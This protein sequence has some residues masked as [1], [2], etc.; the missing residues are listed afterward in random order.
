MSL[1]VAVLNDSDQVVRS[2]GF[3]VDEHW[4]LVQIAENQSLPLLGRLRDFYSDSEVSVGELSALV[5][6]VEGIVRSRDL[7]PALQSRLR[8]LTEMIRYAV[9]EGRPL[10][11]LAD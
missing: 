1:D 3:G 2:V 8:Q 10:A 6:E 7:S 9:A 4:E 11:I 5:E